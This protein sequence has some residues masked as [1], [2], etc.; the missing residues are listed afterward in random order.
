M[1]GSGAV[2]RCRGPIICGPILQNRA[3]GLSGFWPKQ[4]RQLLDSG[5]DEG[6]LT[7]A[8]PLCSGNSDEAEQRGLPL[9]RRGIMDFTKRPNHALRGTRQT[10]LAPERA[11]IDSEEFGVRGHPSWGALPESKRIYRW[12]GVEPD[13]RSK[14]ARR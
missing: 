10:S 8:R 1:A 2:R 11:V 12:R 9:G 3:A 13:G 5:A 7:N 4:S 6:L 14:K